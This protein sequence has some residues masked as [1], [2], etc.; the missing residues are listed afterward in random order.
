[1]E[2]NG[3]ILFAKMIIIKDRFSATDVKQVTT[4]V[5]I[6]NK[7]QNNTDFHK[8]LQTKKIMI[9][10]VFIKEMVQ[11]GN[12]AEEKVTMELGNLSLTQLNWKTSEECWSIGQCLDHLVISDCLYF[13]VFKTISTGKYK[14]SFWES[15]SPFSGFFGRM[16][17]NQVQEKPVKKIKTPKIFSPSESN[18]DAGITDRFH[19]HLNTLLDYIAQCNKADI[20]KV[21][22]T[23]PVSKIV[24]YNLR[25]AITIL[26]LHEH[27]HI[28]QA[29]KIKAAK[30]FPFQ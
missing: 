28:N 3:N 12:E 19:K 29:I 9:D 10:G 5:P 6:E 30:D 21:H 13:P 23:S 16:L 7:I 27:R 15:W 1:M 22:I 26:M 2:I 11:K 17:I 14:L 20:D 18:I 8:L 25:R 4:S 24:T